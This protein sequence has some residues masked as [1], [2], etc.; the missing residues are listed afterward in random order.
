[1]SAFILCVILWTCRVSVVG[2]AEVGICVYFGMIIVQMT[3]DSCPVEPEVYINRKE[4][5]D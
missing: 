5:P 4:T 3:L 1:M 2:L